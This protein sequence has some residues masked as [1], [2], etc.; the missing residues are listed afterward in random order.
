MTRAAQLVRGA[1]AA[2]I[3]VALA[4][5]SH[6]IAGREAPGAVGLVLAGVVALAASVALI[7]R[8]STP[9][10]TTIAV[11]VS[12]GAFHLL[13]G[14]GAGGQA[15]SVTI[16]AR[17]GGHAGHAGVVAVVDGAGPVV[18]HADHDLAA[19]LVG[20]AIAGAL[21]VLYL[22]AVERA[23][24]QAARTAARRFVLRMTGANLPV[25]HPVRSTRGWVLLCVRRL[26]RTCLLLAALRY[27]GPPALPGTI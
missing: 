22:L 1:S 21:T 12:Q 14:V 11:L 26:L 18:A 4:G 20:H 25:P 15:A 23:A 9:L 5:F 6:G 2:A 24:W 3:A 13:F 17:P 19:M 7:G 8:R 27:R 10:R 16:G